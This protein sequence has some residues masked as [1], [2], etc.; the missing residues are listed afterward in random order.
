MSPVTIVVL[1]VLCI[2]G[3][4]VAFMLL[5]KLFYVLAGEFRRTRG[6]GAILWLVLA[7]IVW[8]PVFILDIIHLIGCAVL[9][10]QVAG[11][12]R[13]WWHEGAKR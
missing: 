1:T 13:N 7:I 11:A 9:G 10:I 12:L 3:Y 2:V 6:P 8:I 4:I 5:I